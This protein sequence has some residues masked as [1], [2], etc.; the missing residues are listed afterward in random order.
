[1]WR[2]GTACLALLTALAL[3]GCGSSS[4]GSGKSVTLK[5]GSTAILTAREYSFDPGVLTLDAGGKVAQITL[6]LNNGGS[7]PHDIRMEGG[8]TKAGGTKIVPSGRSASAKVR[9]EPGEYRFFCS[10]GDHEQLGMKGKLSV[11]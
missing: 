10:V 9:L 8:G 4:G 7:L 6:K 5:P 3:A 1:M 11:K 2:T